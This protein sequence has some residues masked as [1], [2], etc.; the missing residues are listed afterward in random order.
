MIYLNRKA[1][2]NIA[3]L[4]F[5]MPWFIG[6]VWFFIIPVIQ[7]FVFSITKLEISEKVRYHYVGFYN[8]KYALTQDADFVKV[9]GGNLGSML[10]NVTLVMIFSIFIAIILN[11]KFK[12]RLLART[13]FFLPVIIASG[14]VINIIRGD[15]YAQ[16]NIQSQI[17]GIQFQVEVLQNILHSFKLDASTTQRIMNIINSLFEISWRCG[18]QILIFMAGLQT[19]P[20]QIREAANIEG[21]TG[22]EY[23]W[24]ITLPILSP[25]IQINLIFTIVDSFTDYSNPMIQRIYKLTSELDFSYSSTLTWIYFGIIFAIVGAVFAVVNRKTFYYVD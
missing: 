3:G 18:I 23:F 19:I 14:V 16:T 17:Q 5:V 13:I 15:I 21:A 25:I 1:R 7:S 20:P 9:I 22:W 24:K 8:Y 12:G 6:A 4:L 10:M 2:K 11:Q